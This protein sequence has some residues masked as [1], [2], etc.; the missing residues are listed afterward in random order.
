M[1]PME[2][3]AEKNWKCGK[4]SQLLQQK[5]SLSYH[6]PTNWSTPKFSSDDCESAVQ[7]GMPK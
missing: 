6:K 7:C 2:K 5:Q 3:K 1:A 4:Y